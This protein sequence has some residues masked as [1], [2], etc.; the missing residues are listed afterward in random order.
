M[1]LC[2]SGLN[3][4]GQEGSIAF[5]QYPSPP[6][7]ASKRKTAWGQGCRMPQPQVCCPQSRSA[8][9]PFSVPAAAA[10]GTRMRTAPRPPEQRGPAGASKQ[11]PAGG[12]GEPRGLRL[13]AHTDGQGPASCSGLPAGPRGRGGSWQTPCPSPASPSLPFH[14]HG[15]K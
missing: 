4:L 11:D 14:R 12:A 10:P 13:P 2:Y 3:G 6:R 9:R 15:V 5:V 1:A 7:L 8:R